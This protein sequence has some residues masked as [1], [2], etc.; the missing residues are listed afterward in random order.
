MKILLIFLYIGPGVFLNRWKIMRWIKEVDPDFIKL[1]NDVTGHNSIKF[2]NSRNTILIMTTYVIC[3]EC[4]RKF[5]SE[6]Q[7]ENLETNIEKIKVFFG[8]NP[9]AMTFKAFSYDN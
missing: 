4:G 8:S 1:F 6:I 5:R 2:K 7:I 9:T 3:D